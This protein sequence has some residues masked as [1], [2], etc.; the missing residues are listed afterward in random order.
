M[1]ALDFT[2][3]IVYKNIYSVYVFIDVLAPGANSENGVQHSPASMAAT[4][5]S[6]SAVRWRPSPP[7][8]RPIFRWFLHR[9]PHVLDAAKIASIWEPFE[10]ENAGVLGASHSQLREEPPPKRPHQMMAALEQH[11]KS[12]VTEM[13]LIGRISRHFQRFR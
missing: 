4:T 7:N 11:W 9:K 3:E 2:D 8:L 13:R 5:F 12:V 6:Q 1:V 10:R